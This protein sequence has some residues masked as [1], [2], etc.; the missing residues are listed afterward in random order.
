[1]LLNDPN[2]G[3]YY[4]SSQ[5]TQIDDDNNAAA[6]F[7]IIVNLKF[8]GERGGKGKT[9]QKSFS[10]LLKKKRFFY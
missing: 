4:T 2:S 8:T 6:A 3:A 5:H 9:S 7:M 10:P 1:M